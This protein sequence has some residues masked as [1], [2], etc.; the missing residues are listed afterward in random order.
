MRKTT[1]KSK[2]AFTLVELMIA[3][4]IVILLFALSINSLIRSRMT[5]NEAAAIRTLRIYHTAFASFRAVNPRYPWELEE[6]GSEY[7]DPPYID[8]ALAR[9]FARRQ[10]YEFFINEAEGDFFQIAALPQNSGVTGNR[11]FVIDQ[12]GVIMEAGGVAVGVL[13][14]LTFEDLQPIQ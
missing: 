11:M 10:G 14:E 1:L 7:S 12:S 8:S 3:I 5:A 13:D 4:G 6:L 9:S 2:K